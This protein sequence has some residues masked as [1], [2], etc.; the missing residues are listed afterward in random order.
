MQRPD[1]MLDTASRLDVQRH[2][3]QDQRAAYAA[4]N[5]QVRVE[6]E[7]PVLAWLRA[8]CREV[9]SRWASRRAIEALERELRAAPLAGEDA[10]TR[11]AG[12]GR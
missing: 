4:M 10:P 12:W 3:L 2:R 5:A 7:N 8:V 11:Q 9:A 6:R 1:Y